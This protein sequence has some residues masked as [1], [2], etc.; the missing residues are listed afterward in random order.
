M[1]WTYGLNSGING[2]SPAQVSPEYI[3]L[4]STAPLTQP[5]NCQQVASNQYVTTEEILF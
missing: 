5:V 3:Q 1:N 2:I 4:C